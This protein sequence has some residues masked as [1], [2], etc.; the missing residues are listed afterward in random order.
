MFIKIVR[1]L[2]L[3]SLQLSLLPSIDVQP[4]PEVTEMVPVP[5]LWV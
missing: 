1:A 5:E 2:I 3:S 4:I